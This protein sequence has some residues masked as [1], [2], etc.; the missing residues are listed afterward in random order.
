MSG[1]GDAD[2]SGGGKVSKSAVAGASVG[3]TAGA[4]T[5]ALFNLAHID[6]ILSEHGSAEDRLYALAIFFALAL[7]TAFVLNQM[8][9][10]RT[11]A[12][13]S[14]SSTGFWLM[15]GFLLLC[16]SS[17]ASA[18]GVFAFDAFTQS[19]TQ[20]ADITG[21]GMTLKASFLDYPRYAKRDLKAL[22]PD[23]DPAPKIIPDIVVDGDHRPLD[24]GGNAVI[25]FKPPTQYAVISLSDLDG[26][27]Q[28]CITNT[29]LLNRL[30]SACPV[31]KMNTPACRDFAQVA[32]GT[33][34]VQLGNKIEP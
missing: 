34:S 11:G 27:L 19:K 7:F 1:G 6:K 20:Q 18:V 28:R 24:G 33:P 22:F 8:R 21:K 17:I 5:Y 12:D 26:A 9:P 30:R 15:I 31:E 10:E 25:P 14:R 23:E 32:L 2:Q 29:N 4:G 13:A 3:V 16:G